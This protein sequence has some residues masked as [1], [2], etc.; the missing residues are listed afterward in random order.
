MPQRICTP[1]AANFKAFNRRGILN[2]IEFHH[3]PDP[4]AAMTSIPDL[5]QCHYFGPGNEA[6]LA[7][8]WLGTGVEFKRGQVS[9]EFF[10]K[11]TAL[12]AEPWQP[13]V[14]TPG[15]HAC[16]LCQFDPPRFAASLF[17]P[18]QGKVYAAPVGIVHYV[19]AHWYKPPQVFVNAV[20]DCPPM[21]SMAYHKALL[22]NGG[23]SLVSTADPI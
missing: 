19:A 11:L 9:E 6:L 12:A 21:R 13:P 7:I 3:H 2:P 8:G 4:N 20:L 22:A 17:V 1:L 16:E 23:R 15:S 5:A 10:R 14:V 18:H